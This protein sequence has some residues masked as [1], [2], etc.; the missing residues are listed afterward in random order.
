MRKLL[1]ISLSVLFAIPFG[2]ITPGGVTK[3]GAQGASRETQTVYTTPDGFLLG[4]PVDGAYASLMRN[5]N[6]LTAN[7]HT[8]VRSGPGVYSLWWIIYNNPASCTTY[9]CTFDVPDLAVNATARIVPKGAANF[10]AW[11]GPG[12]PYSGEVVFGDPDIG[13]TNTEGAAVWLIVRYHGPAIAGDV[14]EQFTQYFG[15]CPGGGAC[16][17]EQ[18]VVFPGDCSG[19]CLVPL[20]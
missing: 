14:E 13:I 15:G 4:S 2:V 5:K 8:F 11:L 20:P 6:G 1:R 17:D 12:G 10:G 16:I 18:I 7:V 19:P 3:A 9:L